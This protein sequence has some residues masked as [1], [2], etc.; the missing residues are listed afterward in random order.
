MLELIL[1]KDLTR[2]SISGRK[3]S[4]L[5]SRGYENGESVTIGASHKGRIWSHMIAD[6]ISEWVEWCHHIGEKL[7]DETISTDKI[8]EHAII[9]EEIQTRPSLVP[10]TID[11]PPYFL[12]RNDEA[13]FV[14]LNKKTVPFYESQLDIITFNDIDPI[15]FRISI[16]EEFADYEIVFNGKIIDFLPISKTTAFLSTSSKRASLTEWFQ[17]NHQLLDLKI[18]LLW[19]SM[20][21]FSLKSKENHMIFQKL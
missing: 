17:D 16:D 1:K 18:L 11:W 7:L 8:L 12:E 14:E 2:A 19:N 15:R 6:D 21:S 9:P 5:F 3:K 4:N 10:L 20:S 13:I